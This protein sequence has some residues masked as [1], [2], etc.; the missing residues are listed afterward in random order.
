LTLRLLIIL[1]GTIV[2]NASVISLTAFPFNHL[3]F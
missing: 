3:S 1:L 2:A